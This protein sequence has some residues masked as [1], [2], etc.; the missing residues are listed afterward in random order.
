MMLTWGLEVQSFDL[1][2]EKSSASFAL[3]QRLSATKPLPRPEPMSGLIGPQDG[4]DFAEQSPSKPRY[5]E[6]TAKNSKRLRKRTGAT[7][8]TQKICKALERYLVERCSTGISAASVGCAT[9]CAQAAST[10]SLD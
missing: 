10:K 8:W 1:S 6:F 2:Q 7:R 3:L 5:D 4:I 9:R